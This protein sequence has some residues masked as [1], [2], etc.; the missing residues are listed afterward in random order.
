MRRGGTRIE[1]R[2]ADVSDRE[3]LTAVID[4][5]AVE[6]GALHG[7]FANAAVLPLP[8][9]VAALDW[10]P[11]DRVLA[12]NLTGG[13]LTLVSSLPHV[14]DGGSLLVNG[15]SMAIRPRQQRLAD[16]AA[17][18]GLHAAAGALAIEL[19]APRITVNVPAPGFTDT[20]PDSRPH[21]HRPTRSTGTC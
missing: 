18:A 10:Q 7:V 9:P 17:K 1:A 14:L 21:R 12:V 19:A 16:V 15:S 8:L 4:S 6:L 11:W 2:V 13:V 20:R 3:G 5:L